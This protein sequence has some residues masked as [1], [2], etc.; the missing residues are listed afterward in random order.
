MNP[1]NYCKSFDVENSIRTG[2]IATSDIKFPVVRF[3]PKKIN[4][5]SEHSFPVFLPSMSR[6]NVRG[7]AQVPW[8]LVSVHDNAIQETRTF[9]PTPTSLGEVKR[10]ETQAPFYKSRI[11]PTFPAI[12]RESKLRFDIE[13]DRLAPLAPATEYMAR[14]FVGGGRNAAPDENPAGISTRFDSIIAC[15]R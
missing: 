3:T 10:P 11:N 2:G 15:N 5:A 7:T 8:S 1:Q 12:D 6:S 14:N 4:A 13:S 9:D